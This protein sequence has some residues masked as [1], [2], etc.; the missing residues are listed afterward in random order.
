MLRFA[1]KCETI[2]ETHTDSLKGIHDEA[3]VVETGTEGF[4]S[5]L[6]LGRHETVGIGTIEA[7]TN[8]KDL[9]YVSVP[10]WRT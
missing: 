9:S 5:L 3:L 10:F 4:F 8:V 6:L 2:R 7:A 1:W